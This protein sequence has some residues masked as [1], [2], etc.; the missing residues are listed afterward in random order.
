MTEMMLRGSVLLGY[1]KF[2]K[3]KWGAQGMKELKEATGLD[4]ASYREGGWYGAGDSEKLLGWIHDTKGPESLVAAGSFLIQNLGFLAYVMRFLNVKTILVRAPESYADAFRYGSIKIDIDGE[5]KRAVAVMK[6]V[7][8]DPYACPAW[9]GAFQGMLE[10]TKTKGTVKETQCQR[11]G[12][13][14][15]E[16]LVEWE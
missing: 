6:D 3:T 8:V 13:D 2:V 11:K 10:M 12:A 15:C 14:H 5:V 9:L 1:L 16:F 7:A 4:P